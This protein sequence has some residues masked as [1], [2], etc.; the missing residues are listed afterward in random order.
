[1]K[2]LAPL[3]HVR[4]KAFIRSCRVLYTSLDVLFSDGF[5]IAQS[6][7]IAEMASML[8]QNLALF[9]QLQV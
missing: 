8:S 1:V 3:A 2:K 4:G 5:S 9:V 7:G 6:Q